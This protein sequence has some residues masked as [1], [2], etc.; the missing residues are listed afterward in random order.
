MLSRLRNPI[1]LS[2][3]LVSATVCNLLS[4]Q[5]LY[6]FVHKVQIAS[7]HVFYASPSIIATTIA[8]DALGALL[9]NACLHTLCHRWGKKKTLHAFL[10][11][12]AAG[13]VCICLGF[14]LFNHCLIF[15]GSALSGCNKALFSMG[16]ALASES[17]A[18]SDKRRTSSPHGSSNHFA[19]IEVAIGVSCL[20]TPLL[21]TGLME[22]THPFLEI[23]GLILV[24]PWLL[25]ALC[26]VCSQ[27]VYDSDHPPK[28]ITLA[29]LTKAPLD[30]LQQLQTLS[31]A[32]WLINVAFGL[33]FFV[34][35]SYSSTLTVAASWLIPPDTLARILSSQGVYIVFC[36]LVFMPLASRFLSTWHLA[37]GTILLYTIATW[38]TYT[39]QNAW[40]IAGLYAC[41]SLLHPTL[42]NRLRAHGSQYTNCHH[43]VAMMSGFGIADTLAH[44]CGSLSVA[45][46]AHTMPNQ[47]YVLNLLVLPLVFV[48]MY[49]CIKSPQPSKI[50]FLSSPSVHRANP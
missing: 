35:L 21:L 1:W 31:H 16:F 44:L 41:I 49:R 42:M 36:G 10:A 38:L 23:P 11:L 14:Y 27:Y 15:L 26:S 12:S 19:C 20:A 43:H 18:P 22:N 9:S 3:F 6:T 45:I 13:D 33:F 29:S 32:R 5:M 8:F 17:H 39:L 4:R 24:F 34:Y 50:P 37:S 46:I 28:R 25:Y 2:L 40:S 48:R 47:H 30:T 7:H